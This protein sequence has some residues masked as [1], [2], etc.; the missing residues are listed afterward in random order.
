MK[1]TQGDLEAIKETSFFQRVTPAARREQEKE[2]KEQDKPP[3]VVVTEVPQTDQVE[4]LDGVVNLEELES[5]S[6]YEEESDDIFD[7]SFVDVVESGEIQ[8][9]YIPDS[10]TEEELGPDPFDTS[11]ADR[12]IKGPEVS[13]RGKKLVSIGSAVE[14]LTGRAEIPTSCVKRPK[15]R[16][17]QDLLLEETDEVPVADVTEAAKSIN[18]PKSLLDDEVEIPD[19][20]IDL[21]VSLHPPTPVAPVAPVNAELESFEPKINVAE[22]ET[23]D[24]DDE[25]AQLAAESI[26]KPKEE[27]LDFTAISKEVLK[28]VETDGWAAFQDSNCNSSDIEVPAVIKKQPPARPTQGP[29][30]VKFEEIKD[31]DD[32]ELTDV[33][34]FDTAFA[35]NILPGKVELKLIEKEILDD[36]DFDPR[37]EEKNPSKFNNR[38]LSG[39]HIHVTDPAGERESI[40]GLSDERVSENDLSAL[41]VGHRDL[42]GGSTTDLS[43]LADAPISPKE[44][45]SDDYL[46]Y[47]DPFDTSIV[48][49]AVIPGRTELKFL[50]K[51]LLG[52]E[53]GLKHSLSD[54][55]F[56]PRAEEKEPVPQ[57]ALR[58]SSRPDILPVNS[59]Q[60]VF[61]VPGLNTDESELLGCSQ[62][63]GK[64]VTP[65]YPK[66]TLYSQVG[67]QEGQEQVT[68]S[69]LTHS[70]SDQDFNPREDIEISKPTRRHSD[71]TSHSL[72]LDSTFKPDLLSVDEELSDKVLTPAGPQEVE[73]EFTYADPFDTSIAC[74]LKPGKAELKLLEN[75]LAIDQNTTTKVTTS[76]DLPKTISQP[77]DLLSH[78]ASLVEAKPLSPQPISETTEKF[79]AEFSLD[80][81]IDPFDTSIANN[82]GPGKT[83]IKLLESEFM[84]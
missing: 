9:A 20:P 24:V 46:E 52:E 26:S 56:D 39:V 82:I 70:L 1:K 47:C 37:A 74:D 42:L 31:I 60:V 43:Q 73:E 29:S 76:F 53:G 55:D 75:E 3:E 68:E 61:A 54:P 59:K 64:P 80:D 71:F 48:D 72:N 11:Y 33:D 13:K 51:E 32:L 21:S 57:P 50:E 65:Y 8:L 4:V 7:T 67:E 16:G 78:P 38:I 77:Q 40:S 58:K 27:V 23:D 19:V 79:I 45:L 84:Q 49:Q 18:V 22:F 66:V 62:K 63:P 15:R 6:E 28:T 81:D 14:V 69:A 2:Q 5:E 17:P 12:V 25:F 44:V 34:P 36:F 10:P 41:K 30:V 83:E 35:E